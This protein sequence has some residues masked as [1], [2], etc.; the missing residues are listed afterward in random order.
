MSRLYLSFHLPQ[1]GARQSDHKGVSPA[2]WGC[3]NYS[4]DFPLAGTME[5][6]S[7]ESSL[8]AAVGVLRGTVSLRRSGHGLLQ[9]RFTGGSWR[10]FRDLEDP[11][12]VF[13]IF[14]CRLIVLG[15]VWSSRSHGTHEPQKVTNQSTHAATPIY[16]LSFFDRSPGTNSLCPDDIPKTLPR[17]RPH[18]IDL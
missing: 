2:C 18:N 9:E 8:K 11:L 14:M 12:R 4:P 15:R 3:H 7:P 1:M 17:H 10:G 5:N 13:E 16:H 6:S